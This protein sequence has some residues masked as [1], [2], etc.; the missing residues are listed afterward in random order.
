MLIQAPEL[1]NRPTLSTP[2]ESTAS[3]AEPALIA[4]MILGSVRPVLLSTVI[5]GYCFWKPSKILLKSEVSAFD[6]HSLHI[7]SVTGACDSLGLIVW[8]AELSLPDPHAP[9][10]NENPA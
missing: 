1:Q 5:H 10:S 8:G 3:G 4:A 2:K 6:V 7:V 9:A